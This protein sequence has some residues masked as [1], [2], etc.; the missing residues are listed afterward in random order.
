[1]HKALVVSLLLV[2]TPAYGWERKVVTDQEFVRIVGHQP[3]VKSPHNGHEFEL[4]AYGSKRLAYISVRQID[5][6]TK[7]SAYTLDPFRMGFLVY[8]P[9]DHELASAFR[10]TY[11]DVEENKINWHDGD[12]ICGELLGYTDSQIDYFMQRND[13]MR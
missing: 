6:F 10:Q 13:G 5:P 7:V 1:M 4:M 12:R 9:A 8:R 11:R 3:T 2:I